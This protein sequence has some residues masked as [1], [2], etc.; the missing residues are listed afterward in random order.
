MVIV[1]TVTVARPVAEVFAYLSDFTTT[2][3]WD[4]GTVR[5]T[6]ES[7]DGGVGTRYRNV[8]RFM[9]RQTELTYVVTE[10]EPPTRLA[11]R[12]ENK[13]VVANDTMTLAATS[14]GG[15]QVTYRA[16]FTFKGAARILA[17]FTAPAFRRL[18]DKAADG[19]RAALGGAG[20]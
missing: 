5:T 15:T 6:R 2:T 20:S 10:H 4:P 13:S 14:G 18:G 19:L 3:E 12:G 11:L 9:G 16:V 17:P 1:R 7:G 8:S